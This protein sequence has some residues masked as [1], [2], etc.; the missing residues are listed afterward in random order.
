LDA[1]GH[2]ERGAPL[3]GGLVMMEEMMRRPPEL[4][5][6]AESPHS[7][8]NKRLPHRPII[9]RS[10]ISVNEQDFEISVCSMHTL[11]DDKAEITS[12]IDSQHISSV[13]FS[14]SGTVDHSTSISP[15]DMLRSSVVQSFHHYL[16]IARSPFAHDFILTDFTPLKNGEHLGIND[17]SEVILDDGD[18]GAS[19]VPKGY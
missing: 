14:F 10:T 5:A 2:I 3:R 13:H 17:I 12:L 18:F 6:K 15:R 1:Y 9:M 4:I 19:G 7:L 8:L 16:T 11:D